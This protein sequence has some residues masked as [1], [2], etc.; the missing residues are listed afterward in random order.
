MAWIPRRARIVVIALAGAVAVVL[1]AV[2][3]TDLAATESRT[4]VV[5]NEP[6]GSEALE[7]GDDSVERLPLPDLGEPLVGSP[8]PESG[9]ATGELVD[10][11]PEGVVPP[12]PDSDITSSSIAVEGERVQVGLTAVSTGTAT[13]LLEFYRSVFEAL[14]LTERDTGAVPGSTALVFARGADAITLTV[15]ERDG[16]VDYALVGIFTAE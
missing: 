12:A 14:E 5:P 15:T 11:F 9:F 13:E 16:S 2:V 4:V 7:T 3:L 6:G 10:G 1:G 8:L